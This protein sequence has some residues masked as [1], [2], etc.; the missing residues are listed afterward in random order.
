MDRAL[1]QA[2]REFF[3]T[4]NGGRQNI[5]KIIILLTD[6]EQTKGNGAEDPS[7]VAEEIRKMGIS[8]IVVGMGSGMV[9]IFQK[10]H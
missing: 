6:G 1:R 10:Q 8:T 3:T 9:H 2:Q 4:A 5:P 7:V